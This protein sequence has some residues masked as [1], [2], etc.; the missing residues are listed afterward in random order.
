MTIANTDISRISMRSREDLPEL[1]ALFGE[2]EKFMGYLPNAFLIMAHRPEIVQTFIPLMAT[3]MGP[4]LVDSGLKTMIAQMV[5]QTVEC[6]YC[7]SHAGELGSRMGVEDQKLAALCRF[8]IDDQFSP[9]ERAVLRLAR[10][11]AQVPNAVTDTHITDL[12]E[13]FTE[14][15]ITEMVAVIGAFGF[16]TRWMDTLNVELEDGAFEWGVR[17]LTASG[18]DGSALRRK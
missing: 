13:H 7:E 1:E 5:A 6:A 4:G 8:E 15:Q 16:L 18:W 10:E 14:P 17:N 3:V 2:W 9:A 12:L 11:A